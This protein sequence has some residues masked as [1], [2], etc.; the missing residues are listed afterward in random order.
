M[1]GRRLLASQAGALAL[2][3]GAATSL[4]SA[5]SPAAG[6]SKAMQA[7]SDAMSVRASHA[8]TAALDRQIIA[9]CKPVVALSQAALKVETNASNRA[10][11]RVDIVMAHGF[12]MN[13]YVELK[14]AKDTKQEAQALLSSAK[15]VSSGDI[16][17]VARHAPNTQAIFNQFVSQAN[18][19]AG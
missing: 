19:L 8:Q 18:R 9:S 4:S 14:D 5:S 2:A 7:C 12:V 6:E 10:G 15:S 1:I 13:A 17:I 3:F 16:A 11:F